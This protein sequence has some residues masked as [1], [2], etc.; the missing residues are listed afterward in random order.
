VITTELPTDEVIVED[1]LISE[2]VNVEEGRLL[3]NAKKSLEQEFATEKDVK[4]VKELIKCLNN[5][6]DKA[7]LQSLLTEFY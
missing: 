7:K 2:G 4:Y 3:E 1:I 6:E 5:I